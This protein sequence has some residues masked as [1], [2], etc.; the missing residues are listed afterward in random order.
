MAERKQ[1]RRVNPKANLKKPT[2]KASPKR[3]K[4]KASVEKIKMEPKEK[5]V[6]NNIKT[7]ASKPAVDSLSPTKKGTSNSRF[8][9]YKNTAVREKKVKSLPPKR[10]GYSED[11]FDIGER[12]KLNVVKG[13]KQKNNRRRMITGLVAGI[14]VVS[15]ILISSLS[16][17]GIIERFSNSFAIMGS[18]KY[19]IT[20]SG[21]KT[22]SVKTEGDKTFMLTDSHLSGYNSRGKT[23]IEY[24]HSFGNPVLEISAERT[25][26]YNRES[27]GFIVA[28]NSEK[29]REGDVK[30]PIYL[31]DI[32]DCGYLAFATKSTGYAAEIKVFKPDM[33]EVF[34]WY[35]TE[36]FVTDVLLSNNGDYLAVAVLK[37]KNGVFVSQLTCFETDSTEPL[38]TK[39]LGDQS[40]RALSVLNRNE[41]MA[42]TSEKLMTLDFENGNIT[43]RSESS[44]S[45]TILKDF[46]DITLAVF[47]ENS[48]AKIVLYNSDSE[49]LADFE[50]N[51]LIDDITLYDDTVYILKG[52]KINVLD[53]AGKELSVLTLK[54]VSKNIIGHKKGVLV[55]D[56]LHLSLVE[57]LRPEEE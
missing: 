20:I 14:I 4:E 30:N 44:F 5:T 8:D 39:E 40:V 1:V 18:G 45:P 32:A 6:K 13:N 54:Q 23:F 33:T 42:I 37:V 15:V 28:N 10:P 50:Y 2:R 17:T 7:K 19:P 56:N 49:V 43:E 31:A 22:F 11:S 9:M 36:G 51:G 25:L 47:S 12:K 3:N 16:P 53:F 48:A 29:L 35:L 52:N 21:S 24:Q 38:Y 55:T 57:Y 26:V 41:F 27:T 46:S 34:S